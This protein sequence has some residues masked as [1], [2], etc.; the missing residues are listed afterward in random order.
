M[1]ASVTVRRCSSRSLMSTPSVR[2]SDF[3]RTPRQ[4]QRRAATRRATPRSPG[5][6]RCSE[7]ARSAARWCRPETVGV[8]HQV[9]QN[10]VPS[11]LELLDACDRHWT[12]RCTG[13]RLRPRPTS[14][15]LELA[16]NHRAW[17]TGA[18]CAR[19]TSSPGTTSRVRPQS[20]IATLRAPPPT[21]DL[22]RG[23]D[24]HTRRGPRST[25]P[26]TPPA[27]FRYG[28]PPDQA[29]ETCIR[30]ATRSAALVLQRRDAR[31]AASCSAVLGQRA[32]YLDITTTGM[33]RYSCSSRE[34][35]GAA[36][37]ALVRC[38]VLFKNKRALARMTRRMSQ[39]LLAVPE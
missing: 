36:R 10:Q 1:P 29:L 20:R 26:I 22:L 18:G 27:L 30:S 21:E 12:G 9:R 8:E 38:F 3:S 17:R 14:F 37:L 28:C 23:V 2:G 34:T 15:G 25:R 4:L 39:A 32:H 19:N 5:L 16:I 35:R 11:G 6:G 24:R 13:S 7:A 33:S 31:S